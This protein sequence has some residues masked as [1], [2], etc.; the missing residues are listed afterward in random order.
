MLETPTEGLAVTGRVPISGYVGL[1][2]ARVAGV[3]VII[4]GI[5]YG[6]ASYGATRN[7]VCGSL[8]ASVS[9]CPRIGFTFTLN[10]AAQNPTGDIIIAAGRHT[11]QIRARDEAGRYFMFPETPVNFVVDNPANQAPRVVITVPGRN[12]TVTGVMSVM[13]YA[14]DPD[15]DGRVV[16]LRLVIDGLTYNSISINYG[17]PRP[18]ACAALTDVPACPNIGWE[19]AFDTT[20]LANGPHTLSITATDDKGAITY[21]HGIFGGM[22]FFVNNQ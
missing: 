11:L 15:A 7:D 14:Y 12:D 13:G 3:D 20:R 22:N 5:T 1:E 21:S 16:T 17:S 2:N 18:E 4:D 9:N 8:P 10:S 6:A 19:T